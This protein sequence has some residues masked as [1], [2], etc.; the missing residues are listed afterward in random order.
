MIVGDGARAAGGPGGMF[1][2]TLVSPSELPDYRPPFGAGSTRADE[3]GNLW[4]R[5]S[6]FLNGGQVYDI[7]NRKGELTD[8]VVI[9][10]GR[11]IVGFGKGGSVYLVVRDGQTS[12]LE[13]ATVK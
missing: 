1:N 13:R 9:P 5:T 7:I 6:K 12:R 2:P 8:R 4:V 11:S 3:D 10:A